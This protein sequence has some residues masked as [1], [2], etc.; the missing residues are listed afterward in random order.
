[1]G[2]ADRNLPIF[3][4]RGYFCKKRS[5]VLLG[6]VPILYEKTLNNPF[7]LLQEMAQDQLCKH[8]FGVKMLNKGEGRDGRKW[9]KSK[10]GV[11]RAWLPGIFTVKLCKIPPL[12]RQGAE[13]SKEHFQKRLPYS[14]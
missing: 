8:L 7:T 10:F 1:M 2:L 12:Y 3:I 5:V 9:L 11:T 14:S 13:T 4:T 6:I